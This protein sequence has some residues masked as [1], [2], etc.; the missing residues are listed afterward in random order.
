[1]KNAEFDKLKTKIFQS[2]GEASM[3]W[4]P[5]PTGE[6]DSTSASKVAHKLYKY[7]IKNYKKK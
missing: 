3:Q 5:R 1:M 2:V 4:S 7:I 6:F